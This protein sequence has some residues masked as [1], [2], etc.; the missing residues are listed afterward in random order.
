MVF[1]AGKEPSDSDY[2]A[3]SDAQVQVRVPTG[4]RTGKVQVITGGGSDSAQVVVTSPYI[5]AVTN[6]T[7]MDAPAKTD[8]LIDIAGD[9]F[10]LA[11]DSSSVWIDSVA[12][13]SF[14]AWSD[15]TIRFRVPLNASFGRR[16]GCDV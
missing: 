14:E 15:K 8:D 16:D 4:A 1:F 2:L 7:R 11:R 9:N 6:H 13:S 3:W 5:D 12:V 10:G